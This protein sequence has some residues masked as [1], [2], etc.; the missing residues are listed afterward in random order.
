MSTA[1]I[2]LGGMFHMPTAAVRTPGDKGRATKVTEKYTIALELAC[3]LSLAVWYSR[4]H[5]GSEQ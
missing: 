5:H 4:K 2:A 1:A 3:S